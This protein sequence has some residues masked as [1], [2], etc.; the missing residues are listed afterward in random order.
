MPIR[1]RL[2]CVANTGA[3]IA[4]LRRLICHCRLFL[5]FGVP[6]SKM[7]PSTGW[8]GY[9]KREEFIN[10]MLGFFNEQK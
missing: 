9:A 8:W 6:G 1:A 10:P 7:L 5:Q 4:H 2:N 3:W